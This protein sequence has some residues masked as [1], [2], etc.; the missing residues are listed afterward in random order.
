MNAFRKKLLDFKA[1]LS[2]RHMYSIV[3][4]V[5]GIVAAVGIYQYKKA[6][7]FRNQA[8]NH[9]NR[10]FHELVDTV[11]NVEVSLAKSQLV[12]SERKMTD[13]ASEVWRYATFAQA[14]LGQL[15]IAQ[16]D[17]ANASKFLSQ[18]GAY[19]YSLS[20]K[21]LDGTPVT[22]EDY[23]QLEQLDNYAK[24]LSASLQAMQAEVYQGNIRFGEIEE[25]GTKIFSE[26]KDP[27]AE[28]I[29]DLKKQFQ[30]YPTLIYDGPF[31]DDIRN[32]AAKLL[33][34]GKEL[35]KEEIQKKAADFLGDNAQNLAIAGDTQSGIQEYQLTA[36]PTKE[37]TINL[38]MTKIEG[39]P[40]WMLDNRAIGD[41]KLPMDQA[42]AKAT[43][44]LD[45]KGYPNMKET[46]FIQSNGIATINFAYMQDDIIVYPDLVKV[47][48][49][50]DNGDIVGFEGR[51]YLLAHNKKR[52]LPTITLTEAQAKKKINPRLTIDSA[53]LAVIPTES[54]K[55][56][57]CYELKGRMQDREFLIYI[58]VQNGREEKILLILETPNGALTM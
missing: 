47:K 54:T 49:A 19:T 43:A 8:E 7:D 23:K 14:D 6:V 4:V 57:L 51:S 3:L 53:R 10:A 21:S 15:P 9:Y 44:F 31:S 27:M 36:T 28:N 18:V 39:Y 20:R 22:D 34:N 46:Y 56:L 25:K 32:Q 48:V 2:D 50:L 52:T 55:E 30:D 40:V 17:L 41:P 35:S 45:Q 5:V 11:N 29:N 33:E 37:R 38:S 58:N 42:I 13:L 1:R 26:T 24:T 12:S 16:Q